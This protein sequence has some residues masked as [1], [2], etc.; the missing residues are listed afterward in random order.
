MCVDA[1]DNILVADAGRGSVEVFSSHGHWRGS[2]VCGTGA[3]GPGVAPVNVAVT[4][5]GK[6]SS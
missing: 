2:V 4:P 5:T 1:D 3:L 6:V